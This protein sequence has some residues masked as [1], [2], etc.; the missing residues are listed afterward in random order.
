MLVSSSRPPPNRAARGFPFADVESHLTQENRDESVIV[1]AG[2]SSERLELRLSCPVKV[3]A[4]REQPQ[5]ESA[6]HSADDT[7][8]APKSFRTATAAGCPSP[9]PVGLRPPHQVI[10]SRRQDFHQFVVDSVVV[11]WCRWDRGQGDRTIN[12]TRLNLRELRPLPIHSI[13]SQMTFHAKA[14]GIRAEL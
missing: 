5:S 11:A 2:D 8:S 3:R 7:A 10:E 12:K 9:A 14:V 13:N 4:G 6:R 1:E